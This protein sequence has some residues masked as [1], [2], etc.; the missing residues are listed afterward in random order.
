MPP[1]G[2]PQLDD[3]V[4]RPLVRD[5]AGAMSR[6]QRAVNDVDRTYIVTPVE[7]EEEFDRHGEHAATDSVGAFTRDGEMLALG[8]AQVLKGARTERRAIS[9]LLVH[10]GVRGRVED[11][12]VPWIEAAAV[13][14][15]RTFDDDLP[16]GLYRYDVYEW[17]TDE[18]ALFE[19]HG[20]ERV[21]YFTENL[22]DLSLPIADAPL[23]EAFTTREWSGDTVED[24]L[25]VHN[26]AFEDHWGSQPFA[27]DH[28]ESFH[29]G[30]FFLPQSSWIV[31]DGETPV[32]YVSC[33][34][35]PHDWEDRGRTEGWIE[36]IG[37]VRSHRGRGIASALIAMAMR[38]F[39]E[40]GLEYAC[41]GVD[42]ESL[43]GANQIYERLGFAPEKRMLT[44]YKPVD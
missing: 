5:D 27:R 20:Y 6:L 44:Y 2:L 10:P 33:S 3:A 35:Y 13:N 22:R 23:D 42:S 32:A 8:W 17:L 14:R 41:L 25:R 19:R 4:W 18:Q 36:G 24:S 38:A 30:E 29:S 1:A 16:R 34:K 40:D 31:Y 39:R 15:L 11:D 26:A 21:R 28:W 37:T 7:M 43:T 12:L 9:W